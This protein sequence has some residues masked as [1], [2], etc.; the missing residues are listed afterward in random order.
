MYEDSII[1]DYRVGMEITIDFRT[2][3]IATVSP[4]IENK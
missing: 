3:R 1:S 2:A 4:N